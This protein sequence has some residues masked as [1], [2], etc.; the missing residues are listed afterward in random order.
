M[1]MEFLVAKPS[2]FK[3]EYLGTIK[4]KAK[5]KK[6]SISNNNLKTSMSVLVNFI[7]SYFSLLNF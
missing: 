6:S 4:R 1:N 3:V 2:E 5:L 7:L